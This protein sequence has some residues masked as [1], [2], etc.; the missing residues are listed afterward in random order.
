MLKRILKTELVHMT[1]AVIAS[2]IITLLKVP[3]IDN[4]PPKKD[5]LFTEKVKPKMGDRSLPLTPYSK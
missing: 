2:Q 5:S 4:Y 1:L 3:V